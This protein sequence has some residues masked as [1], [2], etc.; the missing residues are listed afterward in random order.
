MGDTGC[1]KTRLIRY[2]CDFTKQQTHLQNMFIMKVS[3]SESIF[4]CQSCTG[5]HV[6]H[7][8]CTE[9]TMRDGELATN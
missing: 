3:K 6:S 9:R 2:M 4:K 5:S 8:V 1:G 7:H